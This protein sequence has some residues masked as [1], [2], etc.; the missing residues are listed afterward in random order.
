MWTTWLPQTPAADDCNCINLDR[1]VV[2]EVAITTFSKLFL[3]F[4][5]FLLLEEGLAFHGNV[6]L[7]VG[8]T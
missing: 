4:M 7:F 2:Q 3:Q 5:C 6:E 1:T 8:S